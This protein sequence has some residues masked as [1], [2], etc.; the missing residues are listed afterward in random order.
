M[1][2]LVS[3]RCKEYRT[4]VKLSWFCSFGLVYIMEQLYMCRTWY[5]VGRWKK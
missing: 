2:K 1:I 3:P 5:G 4:A